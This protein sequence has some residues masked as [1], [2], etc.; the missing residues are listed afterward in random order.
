MMSDSAPK[1]GTGI[2]HFGLGAFHRAHQAVY[3]QEAMDV[4]GGNWGIEPVSMRDPTLANILSRQ[5]G[6][7]HVLTRAPVGPIV[8]PITVFN[9][10]WVL[11]DHPKQIAGRMADPA[12]HVVTITVTEKG[13]GADLASRTLNRSDPVVAHDFA[14]PDAPHGLVGILALGLR[15]RR[16]TGAG[17][18]TLL[19]CDNLSSNGALLRKVL[20]DHVQT[21]D[22]DLAAWIDQTCTFP[23]S[24]VDRIVPASN[25]RTFSDIEEIIGRQDRAAVETEPFRQWVIEDN[26]AGDRP[27]WDRA[28]ALFVDD[29]APYEHMKL[30]T[31]NGAHSLIAC[32]GTVAGLECVRDV[33][34]N[35]Q[36]RKLVLAYMAAAAK[37]LDATKQLDTA[38][39]ANDLVER[40]T[41]PQIEHACR[42][43]AMD[44]SQKMPLRV[45]S[46]A[47]DT[48]RLGGN[49]AP[50]ALATALWIRHVVLAVTDAAFGKLDDPKASQLAAIVREHHNSTVQLV[51]SIGQCVS[52]DNDRLFSNEGFVERVADSY[53]QTV[54]SG[55]DAAV[56]DVI[57]Q[58]S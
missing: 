47:T 15:E 42:Q 29:V 33:M 5:K 54:R 39:Y 43:I 34:A 53:D 12:V 55:T 25:S 26:F 17:G 49:V 36:Y 2:I 8:T 11:R 31:L 27:P 7:Y 18:L 4:A 24:M 45:F 13:Y 21:G 56:G 6:E 14:K 3:T 19:S 9:R 16:R 20:L 48:L 30:R 38:L 1:P 46:A 40:F 22:P 44:G 57:G 35:P 50:F 10:M 41:N 52:Q 23:S 37:T 58:T 28:G 51:R 32:L